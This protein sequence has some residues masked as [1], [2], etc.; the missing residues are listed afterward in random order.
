MEQVEGMWEVGVGNAKSDRGF[1]SN[2]L[3]YPDQE[4]VL[5]LVHSCMLG[6]GYSPV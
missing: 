4:L 3:L 1:N 6:N 5:Y 2:G